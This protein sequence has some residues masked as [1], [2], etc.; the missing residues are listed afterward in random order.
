MNV[1][2]PKMF[3]VL[4]AFLGA[5]KKKKKDELAGLFEEFVK[6]EVSESVKRGDK[7]EEPEKPLTPSQQRRRAKAFRVFEK[8]MRRKEEKK[9]VK[10]IFDQIMEEKGIKKVAMRPLEKQH[11]SLQAVSKKLT[12]KKRRQRK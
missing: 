2:K 10:K 7:L 1:V 11:K 4:L 6:G 12:Q 9:L 8:M 5:A 3:L